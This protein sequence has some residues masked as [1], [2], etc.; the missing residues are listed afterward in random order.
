MTGDTDVVLG[1]KTAFLFEGLGVSD[2]DVARWVDSSASSDADCHLKVM[3]QVSDSLIEEAV[4]SF[5]FTAQV[6]DS[7]ICY[8]FVG[9]QF[10][11]YKDLPIAKQGS[12]VV[13][14][15]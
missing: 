14:G 11:L 13:E 1:S 12:E 8:K 9:E 10:K 2:G 4:G 6:S 5:T 15:Y 7:K 3:S